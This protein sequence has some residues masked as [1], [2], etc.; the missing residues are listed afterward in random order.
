MMS[1]DSVV[2]QLRASGL[3]I[4]EADQERLSPLG[5]SHITLGRHYYFNLT[6]PVKTALR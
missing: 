4:S 1:M 6:D 5:Y 3:S 2:R